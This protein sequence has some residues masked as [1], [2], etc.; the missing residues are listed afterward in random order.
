MVKCNSIFKQKTAL[1]FLLVLFIFFQIE[2][3]AN[4]Q[5]LTDNEIR[6]VDDSVP[7]GWIATTINNK[8]FYLP[9]GLKVKLYKVTNNNEYFEIIEG[10]NQG[11]KGLIK[12]KPDKTSWLTKEIVV[13]PPIE[14]IY[15]SDKHIVYIPGLGE[16]KTAKHDRYPIPKGKY[17]LLIP[18]YP[19]FVDWYLKHSKYVRI[20]F[21]IGYTGN[22][23]MHMGTFSKGCVTVIEKEKWTS[24][25][26]YLIHRRTT[27]KCIGSII[28]K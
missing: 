10:P 9:I 14:L 16:F 28:I 12:L 8:T 4:E 11:K 5:N 3:F 24:I 19:Q 13:Q 23:Y 17:C 26:L 20:W 2:I 21:R 18:D 27:N 25:V 22:K 1:I 6:A 7:Y 15:Y